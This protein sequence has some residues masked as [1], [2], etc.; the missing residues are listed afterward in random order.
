[1]NSSTPMGDT[2]TFLTTISNP[3]MKV[4]V[5]LLQGSLV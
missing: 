3:T 4:P 1:M 5:I 2:G